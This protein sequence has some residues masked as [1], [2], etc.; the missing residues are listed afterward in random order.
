MV[1][2]PYLL[3]KQSLDRNGIDYQE[4]EHEPVYTSKQAAEVRGESLDEGAKSLVLKI[5]N[6]FILVVLPGSKRLSSKKVKD[7]FNVSEFRFARPEEVVSVMGCE[8]G[9][10]FPF[11]SLVNLKTYVDKTL[12]DNEYICFNPGVHHKTI[13]MKF[14]DYQKII[15]FEI[16]DIAE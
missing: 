14:A 5:G 7:L 16:I 3:I 8:I 10:C 15:P 1:K 9:A 2:N 4:L 13:K 11:G 12:A 6:S